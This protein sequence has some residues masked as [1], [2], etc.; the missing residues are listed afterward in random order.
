MA[1]CL[2]IQYRNCVFVHLMCSKRYMCIRLIL[3]NILY[4]DFAYV[5]IHSHSLT[6][7]ENCPWNSPHFFSSFIIL[8]IDSSVQT[9]LLGHLTGKLQCQQKVSKASIT[10]H[11]WNTFAKPVS[12]TCLPLQTCLQNTDNLKPSVEIPSAFG[13]QSKHG[14]LKGW[15]WYRIREKQT[16]NDFW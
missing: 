3:Q 9:A 12:V 11:Q 8:I 4:T 5:F 7:V 2:L 14:L 6:C 16:L 1:K 10:A 15:K 13:S